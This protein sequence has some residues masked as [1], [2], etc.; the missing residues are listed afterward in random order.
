MRVLLLIY[1]FILV[2]LTPVLAVIMYIVMR[3]KNKH[4]HFFER[5][6]FIKVTDFNPSKSIWFHC[7][8]VGEVRSIK[9]IVDNIRAS[10]SDYSIIITTMTAT[11]RQT[12]YDYIKADMAFLLPIESGSAFAKIISYMNVSCLVIVDTEL[13]PNLIYTV[14]K[15]VP[16]FL[17]NAR[18]SDKTFKTYKR[19]KFIFRDV[20]KHFSA[21]L[22]K[23]KIDEERF[24]NILGNNN[25]VITAGNIKFQER[26]KIEN[27]KVYDEFNNLKYLL[28]ASTHE[29]EE[30]TLLSYMDNK[31]YGF[32]KIIIVP[33]HIE[34]CSNIKEMIIKKDYSC[35]LYSENDFSKQIIIIDA[36]GMLESLYAGADK[37]F[38]GGSLVNIG[39]HNIFEAL[40]FEKIV[41]VGKNMFSFKEIFDKANKYGLI[42]VIE[43]KDDFIKYISNNENSNNFNEFFKELD[44][45]NKNTLSIITETIETVLK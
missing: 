10:H 34:R 8:S 21:I 24:A 45:E 14:S 30:E 23:S 4:Q 37:I 11:G 12:A 7:A 39:G 31:M 35:S 3:K 42:N 28:L 33:R 18:I 6:G 32:D 40:Q 27:V 20:L 41:S 38:I 26:K 16:V 25:K 15:I 22:A 44:S 43:C 36:F 1:N 17:I 13:W 2:L 29:T 19:F 5:F 9:N